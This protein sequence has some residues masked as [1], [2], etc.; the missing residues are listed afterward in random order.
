MEPSNRKEKISL[1]YTFYECESGKILDQFLVDK[2]KNEESACKAILHPKLVKDR[3]IT[4]DAIV[5]CR[6]WCATVHAYDG[7][8]FIAIKDNNSAVLR[9]MTEFFEDEG[10]DR[11]EFQSHKEANK[12]HG[13]L[14]VREV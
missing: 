4:V 12:G 10:I 1:L 9:A 14:E 3:I 8:Y 5:S 7:Y 6:S 2:K 13:R 11:K